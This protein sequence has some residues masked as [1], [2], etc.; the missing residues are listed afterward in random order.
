MKDQTPAAGVLP[1]A[2]NS[3][4]W[5]DGAAAEHWVAF[6]STSSA[7]LYS[8]GKPIPGNV[9]WHNFRMHFPKDAVLV[10]TISLGERRVETQILHFD[11]I[12]WRA[13][14]YAWRDDQSNA[15]LVPADGGEKELIDGKDKRI[16]QFHS[17]SQCMSCHSSWSE[18]ALGFQPEQLNRAGKDGRNQLVA[19]SEAGLIVRA[20]KDGKPLPPFDAN[21]AAQREKKLAVPLRRRPI[22]GGSSAG[23]S[24]REL[25]PLS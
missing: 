8:P 15:D 4:Q 24:A 21:S 16:W 9:D 10:R 1:F 2:V 5:Q 7:T 22:A 23:L 19:L 17:R 18:Y 11:G 25:R 20:G 12:D 6:P 14:T 13:Y 3:R